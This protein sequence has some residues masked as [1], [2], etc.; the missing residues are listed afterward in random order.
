MNKPFKYQFDIRSIRRFLHG[1]E[2]KVP[3]DYEYRAQKIWL[4]HKNSDEGMW[5]WFRCLKS[6]NF[7]KGHPDFYLHRLQI[8]CEYCYRWLDLNHAYQHVCKKYVD[9]TQ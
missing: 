4:P 9:K 2:H 3:T 6:C 7:R 1:N 5:Y 8:K